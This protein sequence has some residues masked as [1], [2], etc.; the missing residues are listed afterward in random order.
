MIGIL[1]AA[2]VPTFAKRSDAAYDSQAQTI[3]HEAHLVSK[4]VWREFDAAYPQT[5]DLLVKLNLREPGYIWRAALPETSHSIDAHDISV[6]VDESR[7]VLTLCSRS[8]TDI[9]YCGRWDERAKLWMPEDVVAAADPLDQDATYV[10]VPGFLGLDAAQALRV[11]SPRNEPGVAH[12]QGRGDYGEE[13]AMAALPTRASP[14]SCYAGPGASG[15]PSWD[16]DFVCP[17]LDPDEPEDNPLPPLV[18]IISAPPAETS[19]RSGTITYSTTLGGP[20]HSVICSIDAQPASCLPDSATY[21]NLSYGAHVFAV[22]VSGPAG[23]DSDSVAWTIVSPPNDRLDLD[24]S[25]DWAQVSAPLLEVVANLFSRF[26]VGSWVRLRSLPAAGQ[27]GTIVAAGIPGASFLSIGGWALSVNSTGR[28][29]FGGYNAGN[30]WFLTSIGNCAAGT[31]TT[32]LQLNKWHY[33]SAQWE[34]SGRLNIYL[35]NQLQACSSTLNN[36]ALAMNLGSVI[37]AG[38]Q[39][40]QNG[41]YNQA[42]GNVPG[43]FL[44]G[45]ISALRLTRNGAPSFVTGPGPLALNGAAPHL[46]NPAENGRSAVFLYDFENH[47]DDAANRYPDLVPHGNAHL[48]G[49]D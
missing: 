12:S 26:E 39:L 32:P 38:A 7:Q 28:L 24:G 16:D 9:V 20:V 45:Q 48:T 44:N 33:V 8:Q 10:G 40:T 37:Y 35:D 4:L 19:Q 46:F 11:P 5:A 1:L 47:W 27:R 30:Q 29:E 41:S 49:S 6:S 17:D 23:T 13:D 36:S 31:S 18:E 21:T 42:R 15:F 14:Q 3:L 22:T 25:S 34:P 43:Q 2:G